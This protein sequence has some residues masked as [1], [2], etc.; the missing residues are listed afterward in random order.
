MYEYVFICLLYKWLSKPL[1]LNY[2]YTA[3]HKNVFKWKK[4]Y[5]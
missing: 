3:E 4:Q 1:E 5:I 2:N